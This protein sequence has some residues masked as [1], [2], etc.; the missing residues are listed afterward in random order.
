MTLT[1]LLE[2][3]DNVILDLDGTVWVGGVVTRR[4]PEAIAAIRTAGKG[5]AFIT[6]DGTRNPEDYVRKLW[7]LGCTASA[8]EVVSVG[9][10]IQYVLAERAPGQRVYVIGAP[11]VFRHVAE[12]G[13]RVVNGTETETEAD[14]VVVVAHEDFDYRELRTAVR[15]VL[16]GAELIC[17][18]R[19]RTYPAP[20][21]ASPGTGAVT[22]AI[23]FAT[24]RSAR[25]VGKPD[26]QV[27]AVA[28]DRLGGGRTLV[29]GDHL[30]SDLG[31][32]AAAG[33]DAAIVLSGITGRAEAEAAHDP[34]P[35]AI[36]ADLAALV[37]SR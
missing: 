16:N 6:N 3:Y 12:A 17:G 23:E 28:L 31:G 13:H 37:L 24:Q 4:A 30:V 35:V 34:R 20:G 27:F 22:A 21:G 9:S 19:D 11:A 14:L 18:G 33:L 1:P 32:A 8:G 15:A 36:G 10:A 5:L 26:A 29:I 25:S 2:A 7:S